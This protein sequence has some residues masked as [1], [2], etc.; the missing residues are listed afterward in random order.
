MSVERLFIYCPACLS[1]ENIFE[2]NKRFYCRA[3]GY[4][5]F[6][7]TAAAVASFLEYNGKI[8]V[9]ERNQEPGAGMLDLPGGFVDPME[10]AEEALIREIQEEL[11]VQPVNLKLLFTVP[12]TYHYKGI[13]YFTLD[14]F[15][16]AQLTTNKFTPDKDEIKSFKFLDP[17]DLNEDEFCFTSMKKAVNIYKN[18]Y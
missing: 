15:F 5:Y 16:S 3:C 13:D 1:T 10:S 4:E 14:I 9:V 8:L 2:G 17:S 12:N 11:A 7:N 6:H 18:S